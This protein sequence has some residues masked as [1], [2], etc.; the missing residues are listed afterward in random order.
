MTRIVSIHAPARGA[1]GG[2]GS[3]GQREKFQSTRPHGARH[4]R[5]KIFCMFRVSI[6]APARGATTARLSFAGSQRFNPR[7][8]TGRDGSRCQQHKPWRFQSTRP[9]GA[10]RNSAAHI[11]ILDVSIHAPARGATLSVCGSMAFFCFNPRARTGRD[12][13]PCLPPSENG[14]QST[15]PHGARPPSE[16]QNR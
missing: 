15:R 2:N 14:F 8:R 13:L 10:R 1:T 3:S 5:E 16:S 4:L 9:H 11:V 12:R 7:A 6:H